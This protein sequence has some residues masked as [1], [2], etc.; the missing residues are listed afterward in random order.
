MVFSGSVRR[1]CSQGPSFRVASTRPQRSP[2]SPQAAGNHGPKHF[3]ART[4]TNLVS[5]PPPRRSP[6]GK[7][8]PPGWG[9]V[10][11]VV[12]FPVH[13]AETAVRET[14]TPRMLRRYGIRVGQSTR[15][16]P[17]HPPVRAALQGVCKH[18]QILSWRGGGGGGSGEGRRCG[19]PPGSALPFL[20]WS[21]VPVT[22]ASG[23]RTVRREEAVRTISPSSPGAG[24][25]R[26]RP[27]EPGEGRPVCRDGWQ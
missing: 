8:T 4:V 2:P 10:D 6:A 22:V 19:P 5:A 12:S 25:G 3:W 11:I 26:T 21:L 17:A 9:S 1:A 15:R 16:A 23:N 20:N 27:A 24:P 18:S 14:T 13:R 7:R